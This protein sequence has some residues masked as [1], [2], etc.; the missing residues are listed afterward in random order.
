MKRG[1]LICDVDLIYGAISGQN[2]H[3]AEL[4]T[5]ETACLLDSA[6]KDIIR[7]RKGG[8][9]DAYVVSIANTKDKLKTEIERIKADEAIFIDTP[10]EVCMERAKER[11]FYFQWI[12]QEWFETG[13]LHEQRI[14]RQTEN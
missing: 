2:P 6:L 9:S 7:D 4:Y 3:D 8:W 14:N 5:H 12:I 11:P 1:N 13:D 10:Y